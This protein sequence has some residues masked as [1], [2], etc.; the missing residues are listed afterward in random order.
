MTAE[1]WDAAVPWR[2]YRRAQ[3]Q[4]RSARL[5]ERQAEI[6][7]LRGKGFDVQELNARYQFRIDGIVD[8]YPLHRRYHVLTTGKRGG[9]TDPVTVAMRFVRGAR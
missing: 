4:R 8:L 3:Q 6:D 2:E 5:P 7:A 1:A 9:Y